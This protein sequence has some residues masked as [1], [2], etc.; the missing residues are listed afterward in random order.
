MHHA[1][2]LLALTAALLLAGC[3]TDAPDDQAAPQD[4]ASPADRPAGHAWT[5]C[6]Q[7]HQHYDA[8]AEDFQGDVPPGFQVV[9]D[10]AGLTTFLIHVTRCGDEAE[11]FLGVHVEPPAELA[12]PDRADVALLQVFATP[13]FEAAY[14]AG[15]RVVPAIFAF[16]EGPL[17]ATVTVEGGGETWT[18]RPLAPTEAASGDFGAEL[19][20]RWYEAAP[21]DRGGESGGGLVKVVAEGASSQSAGFGPI[22]YTHQGPGGAPP[23]TAG[24]VHAVTAL[25]WLLAAEVVA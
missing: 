25:D 8:R 20:A 1:P 22:L 21:G 5:G 13:G 17:G 16:E 12:D 4:L 11:A 18:S 6:T 3:T 24:N 2:M 23:A 9:A 10:D 7:Q 15:P 19:W 14:P